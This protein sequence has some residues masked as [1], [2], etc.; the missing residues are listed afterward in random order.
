[1]KG[2]ASLFEQFVL[3]QPCTDIFDR[4]V[5]CTNFALL[6]VDR[7]IFR[8]PF[9]LT[10]DVGEGW[11]RMLG[12]GDKQARA[13]NELQPK[14]KKMAERKHLLVFLLQEAYEVL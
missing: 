10:V 7:L 14:P 3:T 4:L 1:M 2:G 12:L 13:G 9:R 11:S 8:F 6:N 5:C